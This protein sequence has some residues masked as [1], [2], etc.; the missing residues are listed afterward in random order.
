MKTKRCKK[1]SAEERKRVWAEPESN[2]GAGW[3]TRDEQ[4]GV[5]AD[6]R[7]ERDVRASHE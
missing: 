2:A 7:A 1:L 6:W 3:R 4:F 5:P